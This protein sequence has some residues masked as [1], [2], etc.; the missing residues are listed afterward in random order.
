MT[1]EEFL[2]PGNNI[3][4]PTVPNGETNTVSEFFD[5]AIRVPQNPETIRK[6]HRLLTQYMDDPNAIILSR[7]YESAGQR[8]NW[9][10]RRG[11]LTRMADG[12]SY[13]CASNHF[14]RI[15]FTMAYYDFVPEYEDFLRMFTEKRF[16]L[17]SFVGTTPVERE[18]A[19]FRAK[20]YNTKFYTPGWYLAHILAVKKDEY[21]GFPN[22]DIRNII[23]NGANDAWIE[24]DGCFT[25]NLPDIL[26][27][28]QK[29]IA[30][31][32]FLRFVDPI[33]YFLVPGLG[34]VSVYQIGEKKE[35]VD[36]MKKKYSNI[37]DDD[38]NDFL[39]KALG[40]PADTP[41]ENCE[42][43]GAKR[44]AVS[45][46]NIIQ[47]PPA[48][49]NRNAGRQNAHERRTAYNNSEIARCLKAYLFD[50]LSLR[51]IEREVLNIVSENRGGGFV[52]QTMMRSFR[53]TTDNKGMFRG[54]SLDDAII[55][56]DERLEEVLG[57]IKENN[58]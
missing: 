52:A 39:A 26:T 3:R 4:F 54:L 24:R 34:R 49:G 13:A 10:T 36:F 20:C 14:A 35:I 5:N 21:F 28:D 41:Q 53:L 56:A 46:G 48:D 45:F 47:R 29:K 27:E 44:I 6:W 57:F 50:G 23:T 11:M 40:N 33:N 15:I 43:L 2:N 42:N 9:Q 31:A 22:T 12:F 55:R 25:R 38:Y 58:S 7:L 1:I 30:K 8:G 16:S 18:R 32:Q 51:R 19:A 37:F 17:F